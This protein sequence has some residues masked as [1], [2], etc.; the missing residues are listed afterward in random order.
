VV[1]AKLTHPIEEGTQMITLTST[2]IVENLTLYVNAGLGMPLPHAWA[3]LLL[4][5]EVKK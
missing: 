2:P 1:A 3:R 5:V 4:F